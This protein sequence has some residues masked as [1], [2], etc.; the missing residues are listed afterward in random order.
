MNDIFSSM[1][2]TDEGFVYMDDFITGGETKEDD[3]RRTRQAL[4]ILTEHD[5]H[6]KPNKCSFGTQSVPYLGMIVSHNKVE[7]DPMKLDGIAK[8]PTPTCLKDVRKFLGFANF[9]RQFIR[10]YAEITR[11]LEE[12]KKKD[13]DWTWTQQCAEA[14]QTLKNSFL[15]KP[16]LTAPDK[17]KPFYLETDASKHATG[18][19]LMQ[20]DSNGDLKPCGFISKAFAPPER[21]YQ[22]Y[23][24]EMLAVFRGFK[25][26]RHYLLGAEHPTIV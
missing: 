24:R 21:N 12:L 1:I 2:Q 15:S 7:M 19:V 14:F 11:P 17:T 3:E 6:A 4:Q 5:L 8:W 13:H 10:G 23:D 20:H 26:W 18:A 16:I 22:I 25:T 9:Y